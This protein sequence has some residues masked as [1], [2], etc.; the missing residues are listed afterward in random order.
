MGLVCTKELVKLGGLFAATLCNRATPIPAA[1][2]HV[3]RLSVCS[4]GL[5][6]LCPEQFWLVVNH[7]A[8]WGD[9]LWQVVLEG[10]CN[11]FVMFPLGLYY[12]LYVTKVGLTVSDLLALLIS[13]KTVLVLLVFTLVG[14]YLRL[15]ACKTR[16]SQGH[17]IDMSLQ[18][19]KILERLDFEA[20]L[21]SSNA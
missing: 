14:S 15:C 21:L 17:P 20:P 5:A 6:L 12:A 8:T 10:V 4:P 16:S 9:R 18:N 1:W 19:A 2:R 13:A 3:V 7:K 11:A